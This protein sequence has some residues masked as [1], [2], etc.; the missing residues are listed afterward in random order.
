M[1][2]IGYF[3]IIFAYQYKWTAT[4]KIHLYT[5]IKRMKAVLLIPLFSLFLNK[6]NRELSIKADLKL[7]VASLPKIFYTKKS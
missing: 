1:R 3:L 4:N 5:I 7:S 6:I 2:Y